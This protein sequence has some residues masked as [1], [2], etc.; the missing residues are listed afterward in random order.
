[1]NDRPPSQDAR[2]RALLTEVLHRAV[3]GRTAPAT[4]ALAVRA[5]AA[6]EPQAPVAVA[7]GETG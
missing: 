4:L 5:H 3:D 1:M 7:D 2:L 6:A